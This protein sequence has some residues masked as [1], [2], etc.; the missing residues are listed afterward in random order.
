[1]VS[2]QKEVIQPESKIHSHGKNGVLILYQEETDPL[3]FFLGENRDT[4]LQSSQ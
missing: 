4:Y 2:L 1:M 3:S